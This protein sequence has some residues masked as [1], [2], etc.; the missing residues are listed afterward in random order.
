MLVDRRLA[1]GG[2][3]R[4]PSSFD[5][6]PAAPAEIEPEVVGVLEHDVNGEVVKVVVAQPLG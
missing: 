2:F 5:T 4:T 6:L 3:G 1:L